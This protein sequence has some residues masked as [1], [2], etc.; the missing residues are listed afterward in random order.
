[1]WIHLSIRQPRF[2]PGYSVYFPTV[3]IEF[4]YLIKLGRPT[5]FLSLPGALYILSY[6]TGMYTR[7]SFVVPTQQTC[8][9]DNRMYLP[10][11]IYTAC[12]NNLPQA[13][14]HLIEWAKDYISEI[15][16]H[17]CIRACIFLA[18]KQNHSVCC[19]LLLEEDRRMTA[20]I[21]VLNRRPKK[22]RKRTTRNF[23]F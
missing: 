9:L 22:P 2:C 4:V 8:V 21:S 14:K 20:Q 10:D 1:M 15:G 7:E 16:W 19:E 6:K 11:I 13:L 23:V 17:N 18:H 5:Q 12:W 3:P